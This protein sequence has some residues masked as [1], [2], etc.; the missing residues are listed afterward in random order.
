MAESANVSSI[1]AVAKFAAAL[2][3]FDEQSANAL[4]SID[5]QAR[6]ALQWIEHDAAAYWR[7]QVRKGFEDVSRTRAELLACRSK[8]TKDYKPS[9]ID[10]MKAHRA[11][12][13][14]LQHAE[15]QVEVV[16]RWGQRLQREVDEYRGRVQRLRQCLEADVPRTLALLDRTALSLEQY[17]DRLPA[18]SNETNTPELPAQASSGESP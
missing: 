14:R 7:G 8:A 17:V 1:D 15:E 11:A 3:L 18:T 6:G 9:C 12:Q 10:E 4:L 5:D 16:R 2:R 13:A